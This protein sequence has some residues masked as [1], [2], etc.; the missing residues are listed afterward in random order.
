LAVLKRPAPPGGGPP[1][2]CFFPF[3]LVP[4]TSRAILWHSK[5]RAPL[6]QGV[7]LFPLSPPHDFPPCHVFPSLYFCFSQSGPER[8][9]FFSRGGQKDFVSFFPPVFSLARGPAFLPPFRCRSTFVRVSIIPGNGERRFAFTQT[10]SPPP[11]ATN[12]GMSALVC[13]KKNKLF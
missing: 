6:A 2:G 7:P 3:F 13:P 8:S 5:A 12:P 1:P 9:S 4:W 10:L 11:L